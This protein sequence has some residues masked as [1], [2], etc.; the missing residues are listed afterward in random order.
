MILH[1]GSLV[2]GVVVGLVISAFFFWNAVKRMGEE[3][4]RLREEYRALWAGREIIRFRGGKM[5]GINL[6][7]REN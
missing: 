5:Q 4:D 1:F 7:G 6:V 2:I 3:F